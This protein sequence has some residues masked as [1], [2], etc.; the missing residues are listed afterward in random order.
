MNGIDIVSDMNNLWESYKRCQKA[1]GWKE[2]TQRFGINLLKNLCVLRRELQSGE[3]RQQQGSEFTTR[4]HGHLRVIRALTVPDMTVQHALCNFILIPTL[5]KYLIHDNGASLKGKGISFTRRRFEEHLHSFYRKHGKDGYILK[6]DFRKFFDNIRHDKL[7]EAY[8]KYFE[9]A[10]STLIQTLLES[11]EIDVSYSDDE[12]IIDKVFNALEYEKIPDN[13][14]TGQR[15]MR[16]SIGIGA[17]ISQ[18]SG[19]FFPLVIDNYC[20]NVKQ[21]K[22]YDVYMDDRIIIHHDKQFLKDL[23]EDIKQIS[24]RIG[25]HIN[26][27]KTQIIKLSH[28]FTFLKT[29]YI[30][31]DTGK[32]IKRIPKDVIVRQ[33]RKI[34]SL[35]RFVREGSMTKKD[36]VEQYKS[37]RGD[38]KHYN[39]YHTLKSMDKLFFDLL[40]SLPGEKTIVSFKRSD[41]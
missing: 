11:Y 21:C 38:K 24:E 17:P 2:S 27:N 40:N 31:T 14:K 29:R 15:M 9:Y 30:L 5:K 13:E 25:L 20:K 23:L 39:A 33:R 34:K 36:F 26:T 18:I 19:I 8:Q 35:A 1:S 16:K 37:W 10:I 12:D 28:G 32:L 6:I 4:E 41:K 22:Y 3:Y 7:V